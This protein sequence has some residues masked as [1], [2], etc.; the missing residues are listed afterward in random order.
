MPLNKVQIVHKYI[1]Y[2][3]KKSIFYIR[4]SDYSSVSTREQLR[5]LRNLKSPLIRGG[6]GGAAEQEDVR[7]M[8][9]VH[10][11]LFSR[12]LCLLVFHFPLF[13]V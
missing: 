7:S 5:A 6:V 2:M 10:S 9:R 1:E 11:S 3:K 8:G 4:I 12:S 13:L